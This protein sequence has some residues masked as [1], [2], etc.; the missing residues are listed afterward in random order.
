MTQ[1]AASGARQAAAPAARIGL[2]AQS[3]AL[4]AVILPDSLGYNIEPMSVDDLA[5]RIRTGNL[6]AAILDGPALTADDQRR[7]SNALSMQPAWSDFPL[8]LAVEASGRRDTDQLVTSL[9]LVLIINR[10]IDRDALDEALRAA[11]RSRARQYV[12]RSEIEKAAPAKQELTE[13]A[14]ALENRV[15]RRMEE[16]RVANRQLRFEARDREAA[17]ALLNEDMELHR[18]TIELSDQIVWTADPDGRSFN[19]D[20]RFFEIMDAEP[21][22]EPYKAIHPDDRAAA[23]EA[24]MR[25]LLSGGLHDAELRFRTAGGSFRYFRAR[26]AA[27]KTDDGELLRWYGTLEDVHDRK[28]AAQA[29]ADVQERY[30]LAARATNDLIWDLDLNQN[31]IWWGSTASRLFGIKSSTSLAWWEQRIHL[32]DRKRVAASFRSAVNGRRNRWAASYQLAKADGSYADVLDR[33][34]IIRDSG[35]T[36]IRAVGAISDVT[37]RRHAQ[38]EMQRMQAELIHVSRLSAMGALAST[39]AHELNQPLMAVTGYIRGS[40]RL[41]EPVQE[42]AV[43]QVRDALEAA[44]AGALRAGQI[45]RRLRELVAR[46]NVT[47]KSE[48]LARLID[49]AS[50]LAFI[51]EHLHGVS[52]RIEIEGGE[53]W[54]QADRIQIQ[55]VLINLVRN[56]VQAM[57]DQPRREVLISTRAYGHELIEV[58]VADTGPGLSPKRL[59]ALFT[60][61]DSSKEQGLGI[62][63]SI[64]RTIVEAHG[65]KIWAENRPDG[66]AVLRF[67]VPRAEEPA[68]EQIAR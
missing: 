32:D 14:A 28:L 33:G 31:R 54:V 40:R 6:C 59:G 48:N 35:G 2:L 20:P 22:V 46:G 62:G 36:A 25:T 15:S 45:V 39:L 64:S 58:S 50:E 49:E 68:S 44:E 53:H 21:G 34:F 26:A 17:E 57:A 51:D 66:G 55:Q 41:L 23:A 47:V 10:P 24:W 38:A 42:P 65:G 30:T 56:S 29:S 11:L 7:L 9:G 60:P 8:I 3:S 63:L 18:H 16:L 67:T 52:H 5:H 12:A 27:R 13:F 43:A 4:G 19:V 1:G 37:E 61:F